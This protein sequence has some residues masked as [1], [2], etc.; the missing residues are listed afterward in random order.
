MAETALER[1]KKDQQQQ[2]EKKTP[3]GQV[4]ELDQVQKSF[5]TA[6]ENITEPTGKSAF[7]AAVAKSDPNVP[8][9]SISSRPSR[10]PDLLPN[11]S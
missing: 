3:P 9:I 5:L 2:K 10:K 8:L 1:Y 7:A 4:R 11:P 6:L